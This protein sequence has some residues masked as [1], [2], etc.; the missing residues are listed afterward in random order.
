MSITTIGQGQVHLLAKP[1]R[2]Y[3][4]I[5]AKVC[6]SGL[7]TPQLIGAEEDT[8]LVRRVMQSGHLAITEFDSWVFFVEGYSRVC[9]AQLIRKRHASYMIQSGRTEKHGKRQHDY[10]LPRSLGNHYIEFDGQMWGAEDIIALINRWYD[11]GVDDGIPEEDLRY[12]KPQATVWR[13][14]ICM[15]SHALLDWFGVRCCMRAQAEIRDMACKM[16]AI[17]KREC[18]SVFADAGPKCKS[19]GY[20]PEDKLQ[21]PSCK[22]LT[23]SQV[24]D[25]IKQAK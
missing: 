24:M 4:D 22:M 14:L 8:A 10:V 2:T 5:A 12:L 18:P 21:H 9:E 25:I 23:K 17:C 16:L 13:G 6:V 3:A 1:G 11:Q 20:C 19:L 7:P 15:N